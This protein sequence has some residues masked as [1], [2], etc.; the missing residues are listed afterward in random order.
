MSRFE[1]LKRAL[2]EDLPLDAA[3]EGQKQI[4]AIPIAA[5]TVSPLQY[6]RY[7]DPAEL[8]SLAESIQQHGLLQP[9]L[10]RPAKQGY[11]LALGQKRLLASKQAGLTE[12]RAIV[13]EMSDTE[14]LE[15]SLVENH[16]R[17][18]PSVIEETQGVLLLLEK[19]LDKPREAIIGLL[20]RA[21]HEKKQGTDAG[22]RT[23]EW[24][25]LESVFLIVGLT[26][27]GFRANRLPLL[28]LPEEILAALDQGKLEYTKARA[29]AQIQDAALRN[30]L[31]AE[32]LEAGL[33]RQQIRDRV[34]QSKVKPE[35][36]EDIPKQITAVSKRLRQSK[37][38][39]DPKKAERIKELLRELDSLM[40]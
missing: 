36:K 24:Q 21:A 14:L 4:R 8:A 39:E 6:R 23:P 11:E 12:I 37:A 2:T 17:S 16:Q 31:L 19:K 13:W 40:N 38:W 1:S 33:S 15:L 18:N 32:V 35:P 3:E 7:V 29:I 20:N 25:I 22:I 28:N 10:V 5:I 9:V 34:K 30:Q 27:E 26:P